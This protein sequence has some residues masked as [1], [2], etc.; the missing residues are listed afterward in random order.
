MQ[1]QNNEKMLNE[2]LASRHTNPVDEAS[3]KKPIVEYF[4]STCQLNQDIEKYS[5]YE[6]SHKQSYTPMIGRKVKKVGT[7][8]TQSSMM[9]EFHF[10]TRGAHDWGLYQPFIR[11]NP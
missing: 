2:Y 6:K 4:C 3:G 1:T 7:V 10:K 9:S 8:F 5:D 11:P